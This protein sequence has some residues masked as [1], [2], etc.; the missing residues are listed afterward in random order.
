MQTRESRSWQFVLP[1]MRLTLMIGVLGMLVRTKA[2][3]IAGAIILVSGAG[4]ASWMMNL[5]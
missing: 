2:A 4:F 1:I 3:A 5:L